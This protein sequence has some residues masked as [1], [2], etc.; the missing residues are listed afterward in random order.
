MPLHPDKGEGIA[1]LDPGSIFVGRKEGHIVADDE[2]P[3]RQEPTG[4]SRRKSETRQRTETLFARVTPEEKAAILA[5][6]D[7]AGLASAA[8]IRA[9]VLG[10]AGPRARRRRP[11]EHTTLVQLL[12]ALNRVGNNLNQLAR[13]SNLGLDV[14][15]LRD[16]LQQYRAVIDAIYDTL[17]MEPARDNQGQ[18]PRGP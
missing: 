5:R 14:P 7:R 12:A 8:F 6:A 13:N 16:A 18:K 1:P 2:Q 3:V 10:D 11:V 4:T 9:A 15:E 17:G